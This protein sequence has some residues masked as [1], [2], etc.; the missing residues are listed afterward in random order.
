MK[1]IYFET[2]EDI[3]L[4]VPMRWVYDALLDG[5]PQLHKLRRVIIQLDAF[6]KK[7]N[8]KDVAISTDQ[9]SE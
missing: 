2:N 5:G 9:Q 1:T 4:Q 3:Q 7:Y 8:A 6:S